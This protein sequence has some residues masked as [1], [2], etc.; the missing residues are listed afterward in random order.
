MHI[1][2]LL[3]LISHCTD[4]LLLLIMKKGGKGDGYKVTY[5]TS[6][7]ENL[8]DMPRKGLRKDAL[9]RCDKT[10]INTGHQLDC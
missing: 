6:S 9:S 5:I 1:H 2:V 10:R 3:C 8:I 7:H 4:F